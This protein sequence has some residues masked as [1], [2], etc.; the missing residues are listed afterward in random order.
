MKPA[1]LSRDAELDDAAHRR[2]PLDT[3]QAVN[4]V[5]AQVIH[6]QVPRNLD[7][8]LANVSGI[9]QANTLGST[10]D[11]VIGPWLWRQP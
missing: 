6:D 10:Q 9:T 4:V 7:D 2:L 5:P 1:R 3:S 8:A 11:S